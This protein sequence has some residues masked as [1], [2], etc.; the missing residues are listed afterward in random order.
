VV[1]N[2][3]GDDV[4]QTALAQI[5]CDAGRRGDPRYSIGTLLALFRRPDLE[6]R[7]REFLRR[8]SD[9]GKSEPVAE[10]SDP[11]PPAAAPPE[12]AE[13]ARHEVLA[14]LIRRAEEVQRAFDER[15][16]Q[17]ISDLEPL[18]K[19]GAEVRALGERLAALEKRL[20]R[21]PSPRRRSRRPGA[22]GN[23]R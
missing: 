8:R 5:L 21:R 16:N 4:T 6:V 20:A 14:S 22:G 9:G 2:R 3:T 19:I 11:A 23:A 7:V 18:K 13:P 1:D 10:T 15:V 17:I 12:P